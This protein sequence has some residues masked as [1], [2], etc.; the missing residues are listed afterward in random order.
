MDLAVYFEHPIRKLAHFTEY[1]CMGMLVYLATRPFWQN[2]KRWYLKII[3]WVCLSAAID[4]F[5]QT[6]VP[7]RYGC[8]ADVLLDTLGGACGLVIMRLLHRKKKS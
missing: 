2:K 1:A 5:H 6:F 7:D 8:V 4:E 3:V